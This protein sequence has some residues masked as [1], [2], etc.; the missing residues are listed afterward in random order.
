MAL[1]SLGPRGWACLWGQG[2]SGACAARPVYLHE[3]RASEV[4]LGAG[5]GRA[6]GWGRGLGGER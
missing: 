3:V 5:D 6:G 1:P 2:S 4:G